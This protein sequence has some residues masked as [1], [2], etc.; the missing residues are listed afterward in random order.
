VNLKLETNMTT[1][2]RIA[3]TIGTIAL[4][5]LIGTAALGVVGLMVASAAHALSTEN[6]LA[7]AGVVG[8]LALIWSLK[9][10]RPA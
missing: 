2:Q 1:Q 4:W 9:P 6:P 5:T 10:E 3:H 7:V 8:L